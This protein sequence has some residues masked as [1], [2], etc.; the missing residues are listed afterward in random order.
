MILSVA[1]E[2]FL[3][4]GFQG[5]SMDAIA[6]RLGSSKRTLYT[7]FHSKNH[8][9]EEVVK[10]HRQRDRSKLRA[11]EFDEGSFDAFLVRI[12]RTL[13]DRTL[14]SDNIAWIRLMV[15]EQD[16][17]P[18][19]VPLVAVQPMQDAVDLLAPVFRNAMA[20]GL[21]PDGDPALAAEQF[22]LSVCSRDVH[23]VL[24]GMEDAG[25]TPE[26]AER[27]EQVVHLFLGRTGSASPVLPKSRREL[28]AAD[29][30]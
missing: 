16:R 13:L 21:L 29:G 30:A 23:R 12:G 25:L 10:R 26:R 5:T 19:L 14:H 24:V 9:F 27:V 3:R 28:I 1:C 22:V 8:L 20:A 2:F 17:F 6:A 4:D 7:R 15:V 18:D 11:I